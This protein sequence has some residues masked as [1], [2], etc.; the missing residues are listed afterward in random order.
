VRQDNPWTDDKLPD[1]LLEKEAQL[2][3]ALLDLP[4]ANRNRLLEA[5]KG[6]GLIREAFDDDESPSS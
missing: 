6:F 3:E 2:F 1:P 5:V 4:E